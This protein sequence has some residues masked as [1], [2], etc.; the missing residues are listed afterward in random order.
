MSFNSINF[1]IDT[2]LQYPN[3]TI[4]FENMDLYN[5]TD[6]IDITLIN[7]NTLRKWSFIY[8]IQKTNKVK[9]LSVPYGKYHIQLKPVDIDKIINIGFTILLQGDEITDTC[10]SNDTIPIELLVID[11]NLT[12]NVC[13]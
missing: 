4:L 1:P 11:I 13:G 2:L 3:I 8:T 10:I 12:R 5:N 9:L 7:A 6:N